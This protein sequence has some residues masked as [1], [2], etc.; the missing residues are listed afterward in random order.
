M[1]NHTVKL[2]RSGFTTPVIGLGCPYL[3]RWT[4]QGKP[5]EVRRILRYAFDRGIRFFDSGG[6]DISEAA[7]KK[8][9]RLFYREDFRR[10]L[11]GE[12]GDLRFPV[13][14][15]EQSV[16]VHA[17]MEPAR[18]VGGDLYDCFY[19]TAHI[20]CFLVGEE[21]SDELLCV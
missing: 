5:E 2:P 7:Q 11:A 3:A 15:A 10:S 1:R 13:R 17:S 20:F 21:L 6:I 16:D 14:T 18:E 19:A 12:I 8:I 9:E 4:A